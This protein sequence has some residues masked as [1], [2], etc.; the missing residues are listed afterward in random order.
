MKLKWMAQIILNYFARKTKAPV[1]I[2]ISEHSYS[3]ESIHT[4]YIQSVSM[5]MTRK[6]KENSVILFCEKN[7][8]ELKKDVINHISEEHE[9]Q[10]KSLL[11][12]RNKAGVKKLIFETMGLKYCDTNEMELS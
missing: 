2:V 5:L 6:Y 7:N 10:L 4:A 3:M 9:N 12:S 1:S 8:P 11:K